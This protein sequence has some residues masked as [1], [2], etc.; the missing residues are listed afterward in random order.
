M[1]DDRPDPTNP[2]I[3]THWAD[4]T[5]RFGDMDATGHVNN[6]AFA[7]YVEGGRVPFMRS[8]I[9]PAYDER[10]R[11]VVGNLSIRFRAQAFYPGTVQIGT[12]VAALGRTSITLGHGVFSDGVC[13]ATAE[14]VVVYIVDNRAAPLGDE[15][16]ARLEAVLMR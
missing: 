15:M 11:F 6:V 13:L 5:I 4:D 9:V 10:Q 2:E 14:S 3:Y 16:R 12:G 1:S 8:G 7:R